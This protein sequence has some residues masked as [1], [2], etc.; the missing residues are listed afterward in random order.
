MLSSN[1]LSAFSGVTATPPTQRPGLARPVRDVAASPGQPIQ[2][3]AIPPTAPTGFT[4]R[5]SLLNLS[6]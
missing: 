2:K 3:Q 5:G 1:A 4:P 6:V